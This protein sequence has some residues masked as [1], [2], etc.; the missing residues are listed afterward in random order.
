MP[1][2]DVEGGRSPLFPRLTA[3]AVGRAVTG[4]CEQRVVGSRVVAAIDNAG[5]Q[6]CLVVD[7]VALCRAFQGFGERAAGIILHPLLW[8]LRGKILPRQLLYPGLHP[9]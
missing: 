9:P 8:L 3:W 7:V 6:R 4:L 5:V 2:R 1:A